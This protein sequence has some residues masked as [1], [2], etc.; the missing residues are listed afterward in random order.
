MK[1]LEFAKYMVIILLSISLSMVFILSIS[2]FFWLVMSNIPA[3]MEPYVISSFI[4]SAF[5]TGCLTLFFFPEVM[6][7][8]A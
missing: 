1:I 7:L 4:I 5:T 2:Y 8:W 6:R 3:K